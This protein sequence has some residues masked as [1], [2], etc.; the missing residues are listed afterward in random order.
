MFLLEKW[1]LVVAI[2]DILSQQTTVGSSILLY[3]SA[4][5]LSSQTALFWDVVTLATISLYHILCIHH[6]Q[7]KGLG[8]FLKACP[9]FLLP[10]GALFFLC[11]ALFC[12]CV[13]VFSF[14]TLS[15]F[16]YHS[17]IFYF[18]VISLLFP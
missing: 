2:A 14:V 3:K 17:I 18:L 6:H 13:G 7:T 8:F 11:E 9:S 12:L 10:S 1:D 5:I 4:I 16:I 15:S